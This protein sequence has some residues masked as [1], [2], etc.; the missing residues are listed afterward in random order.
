MDELELEYLEESA[1]ETEQ[2]N[3]IELGT[4]SG[5]FSDGVT[6]LLDGD[7]EASEKHY[8]VNASALFLAGDRVKVH[9]NSGTLL[10]EYAVGSPMAR[11]PIPSGGSD[12][13]VLVKD[14]TNPYAVKWGSAHGLPSGGSAGQVLAKTSNDNY[15]VAWVSRGLPSGGSKGQVLTKNGGTDYDVTWATIDTVPSSGTTGHVLTK[16]ATG[17]AWQA[18]PT[19]LPSTGTTGYFLEKTATGVQWAAVSAASLVS[20]G[21]SV[22]LASTVLRPG[23]S[24]SV[25]LGSTSYYFNNIYTSGTAFIGYGSASNTVRIGGTMSTLAFFGH[26][27]GAKKKTVGSSG[28]L[29]TLIS[30]LQS[31]GLIA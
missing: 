24:G 19:E 2:E 18:A 28:T 4:I 1:E 5:V 9:K 20:G 29:A 7:E 12:G 26:T 27:T 31:Y 23:S 16:T 14:G 25:S 3:E 6:V 10:I 17:C 11:Y 15:A 22:T 21:Y 30:A 8:R 13:Q